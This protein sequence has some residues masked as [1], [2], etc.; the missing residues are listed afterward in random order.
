MIALPICEQHHQHDDADPRPTRSAIIIEHAPQACTS[1]QRAGLTAIRHAPRSVNTG[2][3]HYVQVALKKGEVAL[4]W[5]EYPA[6][7]SALPPN[8]FYKYFSQIG[9]WFRAARES[10]TAHCLFGLDGRHWDI[11]ILRQLVIDGMSTSTHHLC[12]YDI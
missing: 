8:N 10:G 1:F 2:E 7:G 5:V 6:R 3:T 4:L 9:N 11:D 12:Y